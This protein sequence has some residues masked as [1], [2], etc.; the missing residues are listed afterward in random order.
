MHLGKRVRNDSGAKE[1]I[2]SKQFYIFTI[3]FD[4]ADED[5]IFCFK[6]LDDGE[7]MEKRNR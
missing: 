5:D 6:K 2:I 4:E 1:K 7:E 3:K